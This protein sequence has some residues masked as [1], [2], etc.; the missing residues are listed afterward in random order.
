MSAG[1]SVAAMQPPSPGR[2]NLD[3]IAHFVPDIDAASAALERAGFTLTPFSAQSHR[4]EPGGP[5]VPAGS[6]NRC[7]MLRE[8]YLEF[9]TPTADTPIAHQ[10]REAIAR[11]TGVHLIAFGSADTGADHARLDSAGF[12]PLPAVA[13]QRQIGTEQGEQ[14][15]RFSVLRVPP[16]TMAEGRIQYCQQHTPQWLWQERWIRH[17]NGTCGLAAVIACV[18]DPY[19][20]AQRYS[21]FTGLTP[22]MGVAGTRID[23]E[24]GSLLFVTPQR[25]RATLGATAPSL[26]WIAGY[27]LECDDIE[28]TRTRLATGGCSVSDAGDQRLLLH[29]P[30]P[31][32]GLVL[33]QQ[34]GRALPDLIAEEK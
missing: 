9:L 21:R 10:L 18:S 1:A 2:L 8:G 12:N 24:R 33:F 19:E 3:H 26:P 13:L 16:G 32:G 17:A 11:Y 20:A 22:R 34:A 14:T 4:L 27:V 31:L 6:G 29:W 23:S 30:A 5:L 7:V 15:A 28:T 25:L